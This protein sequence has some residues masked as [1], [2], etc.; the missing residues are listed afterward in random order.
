MAFY[1]DP[2]I[3]RRSYRMSARDRLEFEFFR[4]VPMVVERAAIW[5]SVERMRREIG[6][7]GMTRPNVNRFGRVADFALLE[8]H[9]RPEFALQCERLTG[10]NAG[11]SQPIVEM[12][13]TARAH[14]VQVVIVE[15]PMHPYH[16]I[17][18]YALDAWNRYRDHLRNLVKAQHA[19]YLGAADWIVN[20]NEFED[21]LHL[22]PLGARDFSRR[23]A[24]TIRD[25]DF[26]SRAIVSRSRQPILSLRH[27]E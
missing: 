14:G 3:A 4:H 8:A 6:E 25:M 24:A 26:E 9:S 15:M 5:A 21:H 23:L 27:E 13:A 1:L 11:L 16:R 22:A 17:H 2:D 20:A 19:I 12:I 18:F 7:V 10:E